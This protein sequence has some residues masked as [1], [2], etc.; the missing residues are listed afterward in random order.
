MQHNLDDYISL[1]RL[2][3]KSPS[4]GTTARKWVIDEDAQQEMGDLFEEYSNKVGYNNAAKETS[5]RAPDDT[6]LMQITLC[7]VRVNVA[8]IPTSCHDWAELK[9]PN[10]SVK[11]D[12]TV[13]VSPVNEWFPNEFE[14]W[15]GSVL[16]EASKRFLPPGSPRITVSETVG[17]IVKVLYFIRRV[18]EERYQMK[19]LGKHHRGPETPQDRYLITKRWTAPTI[20]YDAIEQHVKAAM[21][22]IPVTHRGPVCEHTRHGHWR[23]YKSGKSR[24]IEDYKAGSP[25]VARKTTVR[26]TAARRKVAVKELQ[27]TS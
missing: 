13:M 22:N 9:Y 14:A 8:Y 26:L 18:F 20:K 3:A 24:W 6:I 7:G 4:F 23:H 25:N 27:E 11:A 2:Q 17:S 15:M 5:E 16:S 1:I 21:R 19:R 10:K 12:Y